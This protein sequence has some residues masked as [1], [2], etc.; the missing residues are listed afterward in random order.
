MRRQPGPV[1]RP[2]DGKEGKLTLAKTF[3][4]GNEAN[5]GYLD[6]WVQATWTSRRATPSSPIVPPPSAPAPSSSQPPPPPPPAPFS[7]N[8]P[9]QSATSIHL[10]VGSIFA[11]KTKLA[12]RSRRVKV[13][14][15]FI[16]GD[17][18]HYRA[19]GSIRKL[20]LLSLC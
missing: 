8:A 5:V 14:V 16:N 13:N 17:A 11:C 6:S 1:V 4:S 19:F 15:G 10:P 7:V 12:T 20:G 3:C 2:D 18:R 9:A